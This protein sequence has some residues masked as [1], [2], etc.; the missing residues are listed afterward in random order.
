[1]K[2]ASG[3]E[4]PYARKVYYDVYPFVV[5]PFVLQPI[6][7]LIRIILNDYFLP[8]TNRKYFNQLSVFGTIY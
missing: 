8:F 6:Y 7:S 2:N 5:L 1:M 3:S 4:K